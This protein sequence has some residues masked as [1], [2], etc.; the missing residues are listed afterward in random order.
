MKVAQTMTEGLAEMSSS[1]SGTMLDLVGVQKTY[2]GKRSF[3]A[4]RDHAVRAGW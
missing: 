1:S 3:E 2:A 4:I